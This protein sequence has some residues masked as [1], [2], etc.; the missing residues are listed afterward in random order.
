MLNRIESTRPNLPPAELADIGRRIFGVA[1]EVKPLTSERDQNAVIADGFAAYVLKVASAGDDPDIIRLQNTAM[2]LAGRHQPRLPVPRVVQS[3]D[4]NGLEFI[5]FGGKRHAVRLLT[6]LPGVAIGSLQRPRQLLRNVGAAAAH[7]DEAL[8]VLE[9]PH[10]NDMPWDMSR[11]SD[12]R[13]GLTHIGDMDQRQVLATVLDDAA[14]VTLPALAAL[15][16]QWIHNDFNLN[17]L[18]AE[19]EQPDRL[20]G[21]IDF[22]D[23]L[24]TARV[25]EIAIAA[26]HL[27]S[28]EPN[29]L[30][31]TIEV[32]TGY[33][34][35]SELSRSEIVLLPR[36]MALR[37]AMAVLGRTMHVARVG[38][39][40]FDLKPI[41]SYLRYIALLSSGGLDAMGERFGN[42]LASGVGT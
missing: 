33:H 35:V 21:I 2:T 22:G 6:R 42:L 25:V 20:S 34:R 3:K 19:P 18:L 36:L 31:G 10:V 37:A 9:A 15:P 7:L 26:A 1:G 17:N 29:Q 28:R 39:G 14:A 41:E 11:A 40:H 5:E 23:V 16:D 13:A 38:V 8:A 12:M 30:D 24:R 32:I 4:G 27:G